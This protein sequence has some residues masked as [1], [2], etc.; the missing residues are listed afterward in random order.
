M[1]KILHRLSRKD[2]N[3][4]LITTIIVVTFIS[5]LMLGSLVIYGQA[6]RIDNLQR[7]ANL[8]ARE[9]SLSGVTDGKTL[10]RLER[11]E[12]QYKMDVTMKVEGDYLGSS[13]TLKLESDFTV[14]LFYDT[15]Y[16]IGAFINWSKE[17]TY[18]A[19]ASG[20][21]EEYTKVP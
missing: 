2:G 11:L 4:D 3:A 16:G 21:V 17:E 13:K 6:S 12:K 15:K 14:T 5:I 9:I 8:M 10:D 7:M 19:T 18:R 1:R 20:K